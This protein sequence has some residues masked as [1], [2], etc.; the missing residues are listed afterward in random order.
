MTSNMARLGA[1][2]FSHVGA[3]GFVRLGEQ[4]KTGSRAL[5]RQRAEPL[6]APIG[7]R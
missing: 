1:E 4:E 7:P 5:A 2:L 3:E 6:T